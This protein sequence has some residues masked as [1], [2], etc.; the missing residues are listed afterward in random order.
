MVR[1]LIPTRNRLV[2]LA[3][4]LEFL[5]RFYPGTDVFVADGSEPAYQGQYQDVMA[6]SANGLNVIYRRYPHDM[7]FVTRVLSVLQELDDECIAMGADDD[8]PL[9]DKMNEGEAF[10]LAHPDYVTAIAA[11]VYFALNVRN[12]LNVSLR[13]AETLDSEAPQDRALQYARTGFSTT[14]AA[15]RRTHLVDRYQRF[16]KAFVPGFYDFSVGLHDCVKGK[17][18]CL[19]GFG[20]FATRNHNHSY[21][22]RDRSGWWLDLSGDI[23]RLRGF[24]VDDLV[25]AGLDQI[26][27]E[28]L[29]TKA[30]AMRLAHRL[31]P[32]LED[33]IRRAMNEFAP[34]DAQRGVFERFNEMFAADTA[35]HAEFEDRLRH[36]V[37][38]LQ[39]SAASGDNADEPKKYA[40]IQMEAPDNLS[41][42]T[43]EETE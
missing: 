25:S 10:L 8:F 20:V 21:V 35:T 7:P 30:Y 26:D 6:R 37:D 13:M 23:S 22:R 42:A 16:E 2:S 5:A 1:L 32:H 31:A 4:V 17:V 29:A 14:Y 41:A 18:K 12:R 11:N 27:A 39:L 15:T 19:E 33:N 3:G 38:R 40:S 9:M 43:D 28:Q 24:L 34:T 36:I